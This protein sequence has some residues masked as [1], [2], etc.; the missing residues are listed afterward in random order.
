MINLSFCSPINHRG[1]RLLKYLSGCC[2][3]PCRINQIY[4]A[5]SLTPPDKHKQADAQPAGPEAGWPFNPFNIAGPRLASGHLHYHSKGQRLN[6]LKRREKRGREMLP[7][8]IVNWKHL[9]GLTDSLPLADRSEWREA[10]SAERED[11]KRKE[12]KEEEM[13]VRK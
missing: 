1:W 6:K 2:M 13:S 4:K 3:K 12:K 8:Y 9:W 11:F 7:V 5:G 10:C